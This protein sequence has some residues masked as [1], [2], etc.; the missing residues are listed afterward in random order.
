[1]AGRNRGNNNKIETAIETCRSEG[2]WKRVIELA[3]E[4]KSHQS[5][6]KS[7]TFLNIVSLPD[8]FHFAS[9]Q[10]HWPSS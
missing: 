7:S 8:T 1:M 4:L 2:K 9:F 3:E 10:S 5:L 6:G